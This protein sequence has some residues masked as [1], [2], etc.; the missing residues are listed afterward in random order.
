MDYDERGPGGIVITIVVIILVIVIIF[1]IVWLCRNRQ[2]SNKMHQSFQPSDAHL[3]KSPDGKI[4]ISQGGM[5]TQDNQCRPNL[6]CYEGKCRIQDRID[7]SERLK[8]EQSNPNST[9]N[10]NRKTSNN[11][12]IN[13][14]NQN[15]GSSNNINPVPASSL[16]ILTNIQ[17]NT[18]PK[19]EYYQDRRKTYLEDDTEFDDDIDVAKRRSLYGSLKSPTAVSNGDRDFN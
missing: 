11:H 4:L 8:K 5:C 15:T 13:R 6:R 12:I 7:N 19:E 9:C 17:P 1:V 16:P 2:S 18:L 10:S 14:S 3:P